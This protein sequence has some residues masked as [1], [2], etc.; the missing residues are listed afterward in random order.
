MILRGEPFY[1]YQG[2]VALY[3]LLKALGVGQGRSDEV[4]VQ[5]YTCPS[6]IEP[7]LGVGATAVLSDVNCSLNMGAAELKRCV[8]QNTKA[9]VVQHTFGRPAE[10]DDLLRVTE[11]SRIAV[12]EDCCHVT[13]ADYKGRPVGS[14]GD[15]AIFS[16]GAGKPMALGCGGAAVVNSPGLAQTMRE[17]YGSFSRPSAR[18]EVAIAAAETLRWIVPSSV[19][20]HVRQ[21][22][23]RRDVEPSTNPARLE[24]KRLGPHYAHRMHR[25]SE[26]RLAALM[27]NATRLAHR[28]RAAVAGYDE[29]FAALNIPRLTGDGRETIALSHYPFFARDKHRLLREAS[30]EYM[31]FQDWGVMASKASSGSEMIRGD[32]VRFAQTL[33]DSLVVIQIRNDWSQFEIERNLAFL[34]NMKREGCV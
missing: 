6:V 17:M 33:S 31:E 13:E 4:V 28:R 10:I 7:I 23:P 8:T 11:R 21:K 24:R 2:R 20:R 30:R 5:A 18:S 34:A 12:I 1:F 14:F 9:V 3:A 15:A 19:R 22:S 25:V 29:G 16:F 32:G 27:R 26:W